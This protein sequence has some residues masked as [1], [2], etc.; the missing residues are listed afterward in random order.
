MA[1]FVLVATRVGFISWIKLSIQMVKIGRKGMGKPVGTN[2]SVGPANSEFSSDMSR[3]QML[4]EASGAFCEFL[5]VAI[6]TLLYARG[7]YPAEIFERKR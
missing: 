7:V 4:K 1:M 6:H 2:P 5:E 3:E